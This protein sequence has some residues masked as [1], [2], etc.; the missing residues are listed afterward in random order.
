VPGD[1]GLFVAT[2]HGML[3]MTLAPATGRALSRLITD[4]R[5]ANAGLDAFRLDR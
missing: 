3:G 4:P 5:Q 1:D 2:G